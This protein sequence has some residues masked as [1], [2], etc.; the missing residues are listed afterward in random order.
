MSHFAPV[1]KHLSVAR[2]ICS[3]QILF[4]DVSLD[5]GDPFA[6]YPTLAWPSLAYTSILMMILVLIVASDD[7]SR[8]DTS[9]DILYKCG[10]HPY[11]DTVLSNKDD[12]TEEEE[13]G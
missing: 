9:G 10:Y 11:R 7:T 6:V 8:D 13:E 4:P 1:L 3:L 5:H 12:K 2:L